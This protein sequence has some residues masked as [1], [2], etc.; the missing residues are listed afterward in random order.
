MMMCAFGHPT[1]LNRKTQRTILNGHRRKKK[2]FIT[3]SR[4]NENTK[5]YFE[6][7]VLLAFRVFVIHFLVLR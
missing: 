6:H 1:G 2:I 5:N 3:K 4:K 7:F